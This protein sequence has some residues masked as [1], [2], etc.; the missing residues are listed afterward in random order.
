M[1]GQDKWNFV[2]LFQVNREKHIVVKNV[3][4]HQIWLLHLGKPRFVSFHSSDEILDWVFGIFV[5][6][7]QS[8]DAVNHFIIKNESFFLVEIAD[9]VKNFHLVFHRNG[10]CVALY[11]VAIRGL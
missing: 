7:D 10:F 11:E 1:F 2:P 4:V 3:R 6:N 9:G 5:I 8:S